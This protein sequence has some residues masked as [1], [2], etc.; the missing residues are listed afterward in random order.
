[1][2]SASM[3][4][5]SGGVATL[6]STMSAYAA[7]VET[8]DEELVEADE[9]YEEPDAEEIDEEIEEAADGEEAA[10]SEEAVEEKAEEED[11]ED[12]V[13]EEAEEVE[14]GLEAASA[15]AAMAS[16]TYTVDTAAI[17]I[18]TQD[19]TGSKYRRLLLPVL[20]HRLFPSHLPHQKSGQHLRT[21]RRG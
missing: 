7:E 1:M 4:L 10:D 3:V 14:D 18:P 16:T 6:A 13:V 11:A 8:P 5:S 12:E 9:D 19:W 21:R 15:D 2:M 20:R 17:T